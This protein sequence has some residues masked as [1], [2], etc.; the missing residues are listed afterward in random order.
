MPSPTN[1]PT[2]MK[3]LLTVLLCLAWG[4]TPLQ[5][6]AQPNPEAQRDA[7]KKLE[8]LVGD[9]EGGGWSILGPG[10]RSEFVG[11]EKVEWTLDGMIVKIEGIHFEKDESGEA[12]RKIHHAFGV[13][14]HDGA[15]PE[16][17]FQA[18]LATG[19]SGSYKAKVAGDSLVWGFELPQGTVRYNV[20]INEKGEWHEVGHFNPKGTEIWY[21]TLEMILRK[22]GPE[23]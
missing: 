22:V 2:K 9:W 16:Y 7:M 14:S 15:S 19:M 8:F 11:K 23:M 5:S 6:L 20:R 21:Q 13:L 17:N 12:G 10:G 18:Y 1:H 3:K 4:F